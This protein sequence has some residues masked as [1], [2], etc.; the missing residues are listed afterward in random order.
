M[1]KRKE[2]MDSNLFKTVVTRQSD[3]NLRCHSYCFHGRRPS[4]VTDITIMTTDSTGGPS[5]LVGNLVD[6]TFPSGRDETG[7]LVG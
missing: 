2:D 3:R 4:H 6:D 5:D 1:T 7:E